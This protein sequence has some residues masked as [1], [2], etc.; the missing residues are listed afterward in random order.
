MAAAHRARAALLGVP[1]EE[2]GIE[3]ERF[4]PPACDVRQGIL[5]R[6]CASALGVSVT[7]EVVELGVQLG[8]GVVRPS[9]AAPRAGAIG[10]IRDLRASGIRVGVGSNAGSDVVD[11]WQ[12][13]PLAESFDD[14]VF[15]A[16]VGI[17]KPSLQFYELIAHRLGVDA[18]DSV[19]VGDGGDGELDG[20]VE[21]GFGLVVQINQ[22]ALDPS[23]AGHH[24]TSP[25]VGPRVDDFG[26]LF[27]LLEGPVWNQR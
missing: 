1:Y 9:I 8:I 6:R 20:A 24:K 7:D 10:A 22:V 13:S 18:S 14:V 12:G 5:L 11:A 19:F 17:A 16:E 21:A 26:A 3:W 25:W 27:A 4:Q 23:D 2:F 15:S